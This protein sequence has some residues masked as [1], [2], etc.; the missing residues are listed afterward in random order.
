QAD[1]A[2][3]INLDQS[4]E[5]AQF[6]GTHSPLRMLPLTFLFERRGLS[7]ESVEKFTRGKNIDLLEIRF[8]HANSTQLY[9]TSVIVVAARCAEPFRLLE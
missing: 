5:A 8:K 3:T 9:F 2:L 6:R 7:Y 1:D 4:D